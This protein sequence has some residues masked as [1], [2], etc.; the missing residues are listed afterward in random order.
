MMA[1]MVIDTNNLTAVQDNSEYD[2]NQVNSANTQKIEDT[3]DRLI[4]DN[5]QAF[6][7]LA[8]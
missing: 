3:A 4:N 8:K 6:Q 5:L 2:N 7:E 1:I